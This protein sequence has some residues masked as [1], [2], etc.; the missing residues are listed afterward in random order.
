MTVKHTPLSDAETRQLGEYMRLNPA[1]YDLVEHRMYARLIRSEDRLEAAES[2]AEDDADCYNSLLADYRAEI[3]KA[4]ALA[5]AIKRVRD[6]PFV[7]YGNELVQQADGLGWNN[8][9]AIVHEALDV[10]T[11]SYVDPNPNTITAYMP[12]ETAVKEES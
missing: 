3:A 5:A 10:D 6:I 4:D 1:L 2:D 8:A 12:A 11:W 7:K 9:L